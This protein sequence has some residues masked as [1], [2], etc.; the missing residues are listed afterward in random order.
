VN[1]DHYHQIIPED[2]YPLEGQYFLV[3]P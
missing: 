2:Q 3:D 1:R